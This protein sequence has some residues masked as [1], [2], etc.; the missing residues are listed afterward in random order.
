MFFF[1]SRRR[2]TRSALVTGV[3]TCALPISDEW[4]E[5]EEVE[6]PIADYDTLTASQILPLLP[7]LYAD[8]LPV[9]EARERATKARPEILDRLAEPAA[10]GTPT[11]IGPE[12]DTPPQAE[13]P[14]AP[15]P[16]HGTAPGREQGASDGVIRGGPI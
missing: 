9:V 12:P 5:G 16:A 13:A 7:Q 11:A 15:A 6:F 3:Q 2:H 8:E 4:A 10:A 1:S 14:P